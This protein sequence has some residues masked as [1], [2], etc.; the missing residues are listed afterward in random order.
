MELDI[1]A[2]IFILSI[3]FKKAWT[4]NESMLFLI[5]S[6]NPDQASHRR[7]ADCHKSQNL[8]LIRLVF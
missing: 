6:P 7:F 4:H 8:V 3:N 2:Q 1:N 5:L